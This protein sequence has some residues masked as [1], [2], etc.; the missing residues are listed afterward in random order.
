MVNVLTQ[1][2]SNDHDLQP[3]S[4]ES[5]PNFVTAVLKNVHL[6]VEHTAPPVQ[7]DGEFWYWRLTS[8]GFDLMRLLVQAAVEGFPYRETF[9]EPAQSEIPQLVLLAAINNVFHTMQT[10]PTYN[11][12]WDELV[13]HDSYLQEQGIILDMECFQKQLS[14]LFNRL[15]DDYEPSGNKILH[16]PGIVPRWNQYSVA[17]THS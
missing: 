17:K 11:T 9:T 13:D 1:T 7:Y 5:I 4:T 2:N 6:H 10:N 16:H 12:P 14:A 3:E 15:T 8:Y